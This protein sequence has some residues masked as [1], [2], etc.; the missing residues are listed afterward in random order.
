M[1][2]KQLIGYQPIDA[3]ALA[4]DEEFKFLMSEAKRFRGYKY[5]IYSNAIQH[6]EELLAL[7][8][9]DENHKEE[10]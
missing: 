7:M 9:L 8:E 4:T 6:I 2:Y 3:E 5:R 10:R 1:S